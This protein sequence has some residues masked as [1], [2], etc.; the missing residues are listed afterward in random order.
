MAQTFLLL[1][2][3]TDEKIVKLKQIDRKPATSKTYPAETRFNN[4]GRS[5]LLSL[6]YL[7]NTCLPFIFTGWPNKSDNK[8][9]WV[10]ARMCLI[11][12]ASFHCSW[13][14]WKEVRHGWFVCKIVY[15]I[16]RFLPN[17]R[18]RIL[19]LHEQGMC[20]ESL[21]SRLPKSGGPSNGSMSSATPVTENAQSTPI[22]NASDEIRV[23]MRKIAIET[24]ISRESVSRIAKQELQLKPYLHQRVQLQHKPHPYH[25]PLSRTHTH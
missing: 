11:V 10:P 20:N 23:S 2:A 22:K 8:A 5:I 9:G 25:D 16:E 17:Q 24:N 4:S 1:Y 13:I 15:H 19:V 12:G 21:E 18:D 14:G 7:G 6:I 3:I